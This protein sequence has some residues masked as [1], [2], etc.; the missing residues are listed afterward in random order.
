MAMAG[1]ADSNTGAKCTDM[2][3]LQQR[4]AGVLN[5]LRQATGDATYSLDRFHGTLPPPSPTP[6]P[7]IGD[8]KPEGTPRASM[9]G[10]LSLTSDLAAMADNAE[11][12]TSRLRS[13]L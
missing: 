10:L 6:A 4:L 9:A 5:R 13:M 3:T 11:N 8:I 2:E 1:Q 12:I 7:S